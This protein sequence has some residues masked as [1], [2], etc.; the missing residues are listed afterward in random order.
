MNPHDYHHDHRE[1]A[2]I[3]TEG[4][5]RASWSGWPEFGQPIRVPI[6]L[7]MEGFYI[8]DAHLV[9]DVMP[10]RDRK[11]EL[12][13][14]YASQIEPSEKRL[15]EAIN[16]YRGFIQRR[17]NRVIAEAFSF[18]KEF[19]LYLNRVMEIFGGGDVK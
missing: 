11:Q 14:I 15:L 1:I 12:L 5:E 16:T 6:M 13:D 2:K 19:P 7:H 18:P 8:S 10:Y 9:V 4:V 3:V 17:E